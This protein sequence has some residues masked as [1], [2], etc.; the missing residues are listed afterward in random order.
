MSGPATCPACGESV[1]AGDLFCEAC[2]AALGDATAPAAAAAPGTEAAPFDDT[3]RVRPSATPA[4]VARACLSCGGAVDAD[5]YCQVCG[6][7]APSE[8]DHFREEPA[9][10]V[11]GVCDKG[12]VHHRNEDAMALQASAAAGERA[13]LVVLDGVSS[14]QDSDVASLAG[15]RAARDALRAPLP[16]GVGTPEGRT[17][18][19]TKALTDAVRIANDA[20]VAAT[21]ADSTNPASATFA[22]AVLEAGHLTV[23]NVGDSRVY[24]LP[25]AGEGRLLT[26]DD[27]A[28]QQ[29]IDAG[30]PRAV[31]ETSP[32]A[33]AITKWLGRDAPDLIPRVAELDVVGPGWVLACSDGLWNYASEPAQLAAQV[34][35]APAT[36]PAAL[37]LALVGFA[38]ASG[39]QDNITVALARV[40]AGPENGT[41]TG[42]ETGPTGQ[43]D[44][45]PAVPE[46]T[47]ESD[48]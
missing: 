1:T 5:G 26:I 4:P 33:H 42:T 41:E 43:T 46:I 20:V 2:G 22:V 39:G 30:V 15:A 48:G 45:A 14:S 40:E 21:A 35:A 29:Q 38:N 44:P 6:A 32:Q 16:R 27:S 24:W 31:A 13:V 3:G 23:G 34:A 25:D 47:R 18:A 12:I 37:A 7:K 11:A 8:R 17:A 28:A 36:T 9:T 19:A 10:W